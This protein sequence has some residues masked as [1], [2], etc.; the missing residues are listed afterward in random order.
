MSRQHRKPR[1]KTGYEDWR[2]PGC[3]Q[4]KLWHEGAADDRPDL[5]DDCWAKAEDKMK[6]T[7]DHDRKFILTKI[8]DLIDGY[9][10]A[11]P[12]SPINPKATCEGHPHYVQLSASFQLLSAT[13]T[14]FNKEIGELRGRVLAADNQRDAFAESLRHAQKELAEAKAQIECGLENHRHQHERIANFTHDLNRANG[15]LETMRISAL[16]G[17]EEIKRLNRE[18]ERFRQL[19]HRSGKED[20]EQ[21]LRVKE[22]SIRALQSDIK[23]LFKRLEVKEKEHA[24]CF[25]D[26]VNAN[27]QIKMLRAARAEDE[28]ALRN[29][30]TSCDHYLAQ[31]NKLDNDLKELREA[32]A[33]V[34]EAQLYHMLRQHYGLGLTTDTLRERIKD[35]WDSLEVQAEMIARLT[36]DRDEANELLRRELRLHI[37]PQR[38]KER[39]RIIELILRTSA[40]WRLCATNAAKAGNYRDAHAFETRAGGLDDFLSHQDLTNG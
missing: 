32:P 9:N 10:K 21:D 1:V 25:A 11:H 31:V 37:E 33:I 12:Y 34:Q 22:N 18:L 29:S 14:E 28:Q 27:E 7:E 17:S 23:D 4:M 8:A 13:N 30:R 2:C 3:Q 35:T 40:D 26:L 24:R 15:E 39:D 38:K 16:H 36:K 5:C 19:H 6:A 20:L